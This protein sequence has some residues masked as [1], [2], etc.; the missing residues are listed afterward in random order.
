MRMQLTQRF[1]HLL[2][3]HRADPRL[4]EGAIKAE[5]DLRNARDCGETLLVVR[6]I[7]AEGADVVERPGFETEEILALDELPVLGLVCDLDD[8]RFI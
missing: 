1:G 5:I 8:R 6:A 2:R 4:R 3:R 7:D